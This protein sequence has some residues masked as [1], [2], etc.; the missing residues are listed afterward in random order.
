[1][2]ADVAEV[3]AGYSDAVRPK[4]LELRDLIFETAA[5]SEV[6]GELTETLKWG[7]PAYLTEASRSG[8]TIRIG[9]KAE[10]PEQYGLYVHC[11]TNL[12]DTF[13][14]LFPQ[15]LRLQGNRAILFDRSEDLPREALS[16]CIAMAL[17]YHRKKGTK[18]KL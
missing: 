12:V 10:R 18:A 11:Q 13:R 15:E 7:E 6:V 14:A 8:T 9:W 16:L 3:F 2:S 4:L 17:T 1:M 5:E